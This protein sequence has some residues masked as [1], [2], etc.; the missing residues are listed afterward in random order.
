MYDERVPGSDTLAARGMKTCGCAESA[1]VAVGWGSTTAEPHS[2]CDRPTRT[3]KT[4]RVTTQQRAV[5]VGR[6]R[7]RLRT[8]VS[9]RAALSTTSGALLSK[10]VSMSAEA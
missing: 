3:L 7:L 6:L 1:G 8:S 4:L 2:S 9:Q 10:T 5:A